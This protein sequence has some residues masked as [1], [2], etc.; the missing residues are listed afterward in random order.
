M[1]L[2][3]STVGFSGFSISRSQQIGSD[4]RGPRQRRGAVLRSDVFWGVR[5]KRNGAPGWVV[6]RHWRTEMRY[7]GWIWCSWYVQN[8]FLTWFCDIL[9]VMVF[10]VRFWCMFNWMKQ[11]SESTP[12]NWWGTSCLNDFEPV[13]SILMGCHWWVPL[14]D[15]ALRPDKQHRVNIYNL[16]SLCVYKEGWQTTKST[17]NRDAGAEVLATGDGNSLE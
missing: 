1:V 8:D 17:H 9:V 10:D 5:K 2:T 11:T 12:L 6:G 14:E 15:N 3:G 16:T 4:G 7:S 13:W